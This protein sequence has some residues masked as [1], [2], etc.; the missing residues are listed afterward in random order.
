MMPSAGSAVYTAVG[1]KEPQGLPFISKNPFIL[2][3]QSIQAARASPDQ[4]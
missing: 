1:W 3:D 2:V 4:A